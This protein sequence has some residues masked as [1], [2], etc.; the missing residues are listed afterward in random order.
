MGVG[1]L[2]IDVFLF[3]RRGV[4][5]GRVVRLVWASL[6]ASTEGLRVLIFLRGGEASSFVFVDPPTRDFFNDCI[7]GTTTSKPLRGF[8]RVR[9]GDVLLFPPDWCTSCFPFLPTFASSSSGLTVDLAVD[10]PLDFVDEVFLSFL[11][12]FFG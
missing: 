12:A 9:D 11:E 3:R 8:T 1:D 2:S 5:L 7:V 6:C 4:G 10:L